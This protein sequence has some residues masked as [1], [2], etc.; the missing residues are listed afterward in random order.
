MANYST[1]FKTNGKYVNVAEAMGIQIEAGKSYCIQIVGPAYIQQS[2]TEPVSGG[3]LYKK[4]DPFGYDATETNKL[5]IKT[6]KAYFNIS[7]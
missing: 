7:D 4:D 2:T 1:T 3:F 5:W 6:D